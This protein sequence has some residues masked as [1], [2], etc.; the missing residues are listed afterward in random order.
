MP[1]FIDKLSIYVLWLAAVFDPIGTLGG[2]RYVALA[3]VYFL[4]LTRFVQQDLVLRVNDFYF[5]MFCFLVLFLPTYGLTICLLRGGCEAK[6]IDT[7]YLGA[8]VLFGCSLIY[9]K[10]D[11]IHVGL[12]ALIFALRLLSL[13]IVL[14]W[15]SLIVKI[16]L[17]WMYFFVTDGV[18]YL[19]ERTYAGLN[20]YYIYFITT[21][22]I[23]FLMVY[24][25]WKFSD[26][27]SLRGFMLVA[28][29]VVAL[30]L[31]GTRIN[32]LMAVLGMPL[33]FF[34][35]RWG[36]ISIFIGLIFVVIFYICLN[37]LNINLFESIFDPDEYSNAIKIGY[38]RGYWDV[39]SDPATI[40][41]GQGFNAHVWSKSFLDMLPGGGGQWSEQNGA[42]LFR[43]FQGF[44][45]P[46]WGRVFYHDFI[47]DQKIR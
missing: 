24:E 4:L 39:F 25:V 42:Y 18:A 34:W 28:L 27:P 2:Y 3:L 21:P 33:V 19:G 8:A 15:F 38:L 11:L 12:S 46:G 35:R 43:I 45:V 9:L 13:V 37:V 16:E 36:W 7:S 17:D 30:F 1:S 20:F 29:P 47:N 5:W 44:W 31:S 23:I 41:F 6:F 26:K 22:M 14:T 40:I 10:N 32:M